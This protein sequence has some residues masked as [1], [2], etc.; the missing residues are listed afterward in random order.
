MKRFFTKMY[1][2][3]FEPRKI[4]F[5]LGE[6]LY[7]SFI[8]LFLLAL[9]AISPFTISLIVRDGISDYSY[10][11]LE[12]ILIEDMLE[13]DLKIENGLL[14]GTSISPFLIDEAI[15]H[16]NPNNVEFPFSA[17]YA[18]Y[19]KIELKKEGIEVSFL[20]NVIYSKTY[21]ELGYTNIDFNKIVEAD[22]IELDKLVSLLNVG[23]NNIK[24]GWVA[25]N[26]LFML[27]D[28]YLTVIFTA[29]VFAFIVRVINPM[30]GFNLRFKAALDA[31]VILILSLLL[32]LLFR[33]EIFRY[34]GIVVSAIYLFLTMISIVRIEM[35]KKV[36]ED[37]SKEE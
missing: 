24:A 4:A 2:C 32:M 13:S 14:S 10:G 20:N 12:E 37:K 5:F 8:H 26:S 7:K 16:I 25:I 36:F 30:L 29:L 33:S 18:I 31:Q 35:A 3:L 15:I 9:V 27:I 23:F 28:I 6:K 1:I 17:E 22:Y 34:V 19:H 21:N 11:I